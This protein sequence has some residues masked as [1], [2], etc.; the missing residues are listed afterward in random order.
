M[1][2]KLDDD[3]SSRNERDDVHGMNRRR[4]ADD[5]LIMKQFL[6]LVPV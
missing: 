2:I 1:L 5:E 4:G 6:S 3:S